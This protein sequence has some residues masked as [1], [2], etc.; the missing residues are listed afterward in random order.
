MLREG[1]TFAFEPKYIIPGIGIAGI[2]NT[3]R[4]TARGLESLNLSGEQLVV[5]QTGPASGRS[6]ATG[7]QRSAA[8]PPGE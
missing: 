7:G 5:V 2:E 6:G 1:M 8:R 3:Y 4:V